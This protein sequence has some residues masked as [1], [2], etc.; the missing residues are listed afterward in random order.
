M[1]FLLFLGRMVDRHHNLHRIH[2]MVSILIEKRGAYCMIF[3][4]LE[5]FDENEWFIIISLVLVLTI[6]LL[7]PKKF[8]PMVVVFVIL[9]NV[10]LGQ[11][12]DYI[13]AV[14]PY[15][16]YD[17][18]DHK[19]YELFD[20]IIYFL[21]YPPTAYL[22]LYLY[23][24]CRIKGVFVIAYIVG[25]AL[26]TTG[27]EWMAYLFGVFKY[28]GWKLIYSTPVYIAVYTLNILILQFVQHFLRRK[29]NNHAM[30]N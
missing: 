1:E 20:G 24:K 3:Y 8:A 19:K 10:F 6:C 14:P 11:T 23:V 15:D 5:K 26:F 30:K 21:L 4:P 16:L 25:W 7:L 27:L 18:N 13:L 22:V 29:Q 12:V 17:I 28:R 9:F 2:G